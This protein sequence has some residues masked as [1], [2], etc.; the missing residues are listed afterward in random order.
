M[1]QDH[2]IA[3]VVINEAVAKMINDEVRDHPHVEVGGKFVGFLRAGAS[4]R[5][6]IFVTHSL[7]AGPGAHRTATEHLGDAKYQERQ[8]RQMESIRP[9]IEHLG[10]WHSHH[11]N[12]YDTLS[13]GDIR[14]YFETVNDPGH[15][16]D[17]FYALL[18]TDS[19]GFK[20][21]RHFLFE[22][23]RTDFV[24]IPFDCVSVCRSEEAERLFAAQPPSQ[25]AAPPDSTVTAGSIESEA[26]TPPSP[27]S[28]ASEAPGS[29]A[30]AG[31]PP[32]VQMALDGFRRRLGDDQVQV[33]PE[34]GRWAIL[35][36]LTRPEANYRVAYLLPS[37]DSGHDAALEIRAADAAGAFEHTCIW[38]DLAAIGANQVEAIVDGLATRVIP[39]LR[40]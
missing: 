25:V 18:V 32:W 7:D 24:E 36:R 30:A 14:G 23:G 33:R 8:F 11:P 13:G 40:P 6:E 28:M 2:N 1:R 27:D 29:A 21:S 17:W 16:H 3:R 38:T 9:D 26:A 5:V 19:R 37:T 20:S 15:N 22:R 31:T 10:S 4:S 39:V 35:C 34:A 12:G